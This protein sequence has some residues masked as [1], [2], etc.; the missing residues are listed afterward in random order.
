M[1]Y[2]YCQRGSDS[3][4]AIVRRMNEIEPG[5]ARR[6][7]RLDFRSPALPEGAVLVN[8]GEHIPTIGLSGSQTLLNGTLVNSKLV[9][10]RRLADRG[11]RVPPHGLER[12]PGW[13]ARTNHH[14]EARDLRA[15]LAR[16]D[17]YVGFVPTTHEFRIHIAGG[18]SI[19][20]GH[21]VP[22]IEHPDP[23]FRSHEAGWKLVYDAECQRLMRPSY[24]DAAKA[25]VEAVGYDFGAVDV[26]VMEN[27]QPVVFEV[28][29]APGLE[30]H[31][32]DAYATYFL[33]VR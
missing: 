1:V 26:G 10:L 27:G 33:G 18:K 2:I 14:Q 9:E 22:R 5:S 8:W 4:R 16:G 21:K 3:A 17:Y 29:S 6:L 19:R 13:F 12:Q 28:N 15:N 30:G 11:V 7:R 20:A 25:A 23:R 24:R 32:I 31:S